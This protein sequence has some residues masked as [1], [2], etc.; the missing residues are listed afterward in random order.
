MGLE[1]ASWGT[2]RKELG[3]DGFVGYYDCMKGKGGFDQ[4]YTWSILVYQKRF[5][6]MGSTG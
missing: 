5:G 1:V 2:D 3:Y 6:F 4:A